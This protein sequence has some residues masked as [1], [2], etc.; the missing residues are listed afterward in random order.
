MH[1]LRLSIQQPDHN[2][3]GKQR[4]ALRVINHS[5]SRVAQHKVIEHNSFYYFETLGKIQC[6]IGFQT[7]TSTYVTCK[8]IISTHGM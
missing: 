4:K 3:I 5:V 8:S 1:T 2:T 6:L 7:P